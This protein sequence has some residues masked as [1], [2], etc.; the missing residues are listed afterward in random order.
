MSLDP[1]N[2]DAHIILGYLRAYEGELAEGVAECEMGLRINPNHDEGWITLAD[3]R[4]LE[5]RA[6]EAIECARNAFR[7]NPHPPG[8]YYWLLGFAQYAAG[9]Y[10]DAV[11]TLRHESASGPGIATHPGGRP[12][13]TRK[14]CQRPRKRHENSCWSFRISRR[15]NGEAHSH[16]AMILTGSISSTDTS[17][18]VCRSEIGAGGSGILYMG[19]AAVAMG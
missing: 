2:A 11:D 8:D 16:S 10:Q 1:D 14:N 15:G 4:V 19:V 13:A 3:L 7:L 5:G 17:R 12:G 18:L 6:V 9:R